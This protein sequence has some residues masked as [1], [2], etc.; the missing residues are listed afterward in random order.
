MCHLSFHAAGE[1]AS[2]SPTSAS[3]VAERLVLHGNAWPERRL[4]RGDFIYV[5][6]GWWIWSKA[7]GAVM[8]LRHS[9]PRLRPPPPFLLHDERRKLT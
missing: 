1:F 7:L 6:A 5:P 3:G 2:L 4:V 9:L 8:T